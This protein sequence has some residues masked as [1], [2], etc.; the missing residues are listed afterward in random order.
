VKSIRSMWVAAAA[1]GLPLALIGAACS[2]DDGSASGTTATS[3]VRPTTSSTA[4]PQPTSSTTPPVEQAPPP[5]TVSLTSVA[6]AREPTAMAARPG[7]DLVYVTERGGTVRVYDASGPEWFDEGVA[8]DVSDGLE[9]G[10]NEQGLLGIAIDESGET[11]VVN[12]TAE[13]SGGATTVVEQYEFDGAVFDTSTADV[14]LTQDQPFPNH[15]GG[16]VVFGPDGALFVGFGDGGAQGDPDDRAQDPSQLLGKI[17]RIDVAAGGELTPE[18]WVTGTRN[19]WRFSFDAPTGDL[20]V[21]DVGGNALEEIDHLPADGAVAAGHG[22]NLGW[23]LREGDRDTGSS[24]DRSGFTDPVHVYDHDNG[25]SVTGGYVYRGSAIPGFEG[26]Y[27]FSDFCE[28][29]I[30]A[31][32]PVDG[33]LTLVTYDAGASSVSSFGVGLDGELYVLSLDG[34]ISRITSA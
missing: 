10:F 25:C 28:A 20:W 29:T 7:T 8:L 1:V 9:T 24:G 19:P 14:L 23:N 3:E 26:A 33:G 5:E 4:P 18:I 27:L 31:L 11:V 13:G 22:V 30:R 32:V 17:V 12:Y 6:D 34:D 2:D 21:A 16:Q 15:N